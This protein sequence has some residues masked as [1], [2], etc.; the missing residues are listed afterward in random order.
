MTIE[1]PTFRIHLKTEKDELQRKICNEIT[2]PFLS[3]KGV[4]KCILEHKKEKEKKI[5]R[6]STPISTFN[7]LSK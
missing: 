4:P 6:Y 3:L 1:I 7:S 2:Q 5:I